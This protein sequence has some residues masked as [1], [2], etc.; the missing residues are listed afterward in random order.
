MGTQESI[1]LPDRGVPD[2]AHD[3]SNRVISAGAMPTRTPPRAWVRAPA[4]R[5]SE[6]PRGTLAYGVGG[7]PEGTFN[8]TL[9]IDA[10]QANGPFNAGWP[11]RRRSPA[12]PVARGPRTG[13]GRFWGTR[14]ASGAGF[15][16][17]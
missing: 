2:D 16:T 14:S 12:A 5:G 3:L 6:I 17:S 7:A 1:R 8:A 9:F 4:E 11:S 15:V 10:L 13:G